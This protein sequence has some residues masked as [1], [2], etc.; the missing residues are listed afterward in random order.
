[1]VMPNN[2]SILQDR[3]SNLF[4][5]TQQIIRKSYVLALWIDI[6]NDLRW[7]VG[8]V[9]HQCQHVNLSTGFSIS[10]SA[11]VIL[12]MNLHVSQKTWV[13]FRWQ[14]Y[15]HSS[16]DRYQARR[17][18]LSSVPY[19]GPM[20]DEFSFV[21]ID[22]ARK[23]IMNTAVKSSPL[24]I[25]PSPLL[26][27]CADVFAPIIGHIHTGLVPRNFQDGTSSTPLEEARHGQGWSCKL[28]TTIQPV[29]HFKYS[30]D[31]HCT[32]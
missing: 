23:V 14:A 19:S 10:A 18:T 6:S 29:D 9:N 20:L 28:S 5:K 3:K 13:R 32:G 7:D 1:M 2:W 21:T 8:D 27:D 26:R 22:E 30:N 31:W 11:C 12:T 16:D 15:A 4:V 17:F 25:L 24:C